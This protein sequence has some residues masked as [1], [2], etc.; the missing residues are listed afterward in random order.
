MRNGTYTGKRKE[1]EMDAQARKRASTASAPQERKTTRPQAT[2]APQGAESAFGAKRSKATPDQVL[3]RAKQAALAIEAAG[4][5]LAKAVD[6]M[7]AATG[8][9]RKRGI[10]KAERD[11]RW[12]TSWHE[13]MLILHEHADALL[14]FLT[15]FCDAPCFRHLDRAERDRERK[16]RRAEI[17]ARLQDGGER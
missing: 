16:E 6:R 9:W 1:T 10:A 14:V 3:E 13:T 4:T 7:Q 17:T 8:A 2:D 12:Q 5:L 15:T 11:A